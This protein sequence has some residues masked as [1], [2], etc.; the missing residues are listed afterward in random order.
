MSPVDLQRYQDTTRQW[1]ERLRDQIYA[2]FEK[3]EADLPVGAPLADRPPGR[4]VRRPWQRKDHTGIDGGGGV[5]SLMNGRVFEK[6][7]VHTST[8]H[9]EFAPEFRRRSPAPRTIPASGRPAIR[10]SPICT[11]RTCRPST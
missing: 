8:V 11:T 9:G 4:F 7:G 1:F 3:I 6:V 5:M 10:S 2:S